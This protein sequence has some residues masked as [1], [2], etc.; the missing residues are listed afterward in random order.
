MLPE[1][2][3]EVQSQV[4]RV[5][6]QRNAERVRQFLRNLVIESNSLGSWRRYLGCR[7]S[8]LWSASA[9]PKDQRLREATGRF[10]VRLSHAYT[11]YGIPLLTQRE[12]ACWRACKSAALA[13]L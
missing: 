2:P 12:V 9:S 4:T 7:S 8:A 13:T 1:R 10:L 3:G 6:N 5:G 11:L